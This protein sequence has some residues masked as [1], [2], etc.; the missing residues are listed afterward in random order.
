[1]IRCLPILLFLVLGVPVGIHVAELGRMLGWLGNGEP[2]QN[3]GTFLI[4]GKLLTGY[5]YLGPLADYLAA[6]T[7]ADVP[8]YVVST[9]PEHGYWLSYLAYPRLVHFALLD[10]YVRKRFQQIERRRF[11]LV[12]IPP[13]NSARWREE[14]L[15]SLLDMLAPGRGCR[16]IHRDPWGPLVFEVRR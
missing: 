12:L 16:M 10:K 13:Q 5:E 11:L 4:E 9:D 15:R 7:P 1:M 3:Q 6:K 2:V 8:I 14:S